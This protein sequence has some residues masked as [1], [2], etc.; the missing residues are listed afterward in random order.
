MWK[1]PYSR[2]KNVFTGSLTGFIFFFLLI[3]SAS[4]TTE[5]K[6]NP[7]ARAT[8]KVLNS[9]SHDPTAFTQGFVY[10]DGFLYESTGLY[11]KSSLR[12]TNPATGEVLAKVNLP[13]KFFG[14]GLTV[15]GKSIYQL[16]WKSGRGFIYGKENLQ[17]KG[18]FT[19]ST[20]G[21]GLTDN[22]T[23]LI[24]SDGTEKL[25][26][27]SPESFEVTK[28]L[29]VKEGGSPVSMLNE[30][31]YAGGKIYCNI[32]NSDDIV[33]VNPE[34]GVVERRISLGEL[35]KRLSLPER[36]EVL[37]GIAWKSSS[38]TFFITGKYW[39][40]VFEIRIDS[41]SP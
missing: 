11:G 31:E 39:S 34:S 21:W 26:F 6:E 14:E 4:S 8:F 30:L 29:S 32:W 18:S 10:R 20:E 3:F 1:K 33:V 9:F 12:K 38:D 15:I 5:S 19:Y 22:G 23:S 2:R 35:R 24:M 27:L 7:P 40:E 41:A 16:T 36:A 13:Q 37:N 25:Y 28:T 17:R